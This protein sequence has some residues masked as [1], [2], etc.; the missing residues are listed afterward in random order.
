MSKPVNDVRST[1]FDARYAG[2]VFSGHMSEAIAQAKAQ[3]DFEPRRHGRGELE[4]FLRIDDKK[5]ASL[6][7]EQA[8]SVDRQLTIQDRDSLVPDDIQ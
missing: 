1:S 3:P 5:R 4:R 6:Y 8:Q 2:V 7:P